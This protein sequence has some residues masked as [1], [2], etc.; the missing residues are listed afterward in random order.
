MLTIVITFCAL[1][2]S[3][4]DQAEDEALKMDENSFSQTENWQDILPN[5]FSTNGI[6]VEDAASL[7]DAIELAEAGSTI[8]LAPTDYNASIVLDRSD[9]SLIGMN[10]SN[11]AKATLSSLSIADNAANLLFSNIESPA[12]PD[13]FR[14]KLDDAQAFS[15]ARKRSKAPITVAR[16]SMSGNIAH[17]IFEIK[18][19]DGPYDIVRLH[20]V[21]RERRP[22]RIQPTQ[23]EVFMVHGASQDFE[24]IFYYAGEYENV[25]PMT[26][27]PEYL[28]SQGIDVWG[29]SLGWT[30]IPIDETDLTT[31]Q[32]WDLGK[33]VKHTLSAM[34]AARLI[35]ILTGQ[36]FGKLNLLGFSY[37]GAIAY[38]AA[39]KETQQHPIFRDI[40]GIIPVDFGLKYEPNEQNMPYIETEC[41]I[42]EN[43]KQQIADGN[44]VNDF[45][46]FIGLGNLAAIDPEGPSPVV[47]ELTN[48][49]FLLSTAV[50]PSANPSTEAW[51]FAAG[52]PAGLFFTD[53]DRWMAL[54]QHLA[55]YMP[56]FPRYELSKCFCNED[57]SSLDDYLEQIQVPILY[58]GAGGGFTDV[59]EYT[60]T[61]TASN[62]ISS[63]IASVNS[64]A[65]EDFG[66]ADLFMANN[67]PELVWDPLAL[68]LLNHH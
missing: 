23:G 30:A 42:S 15:K 32:E 1:I 68:W 36:G 39:G 28:A 14:V 7:S 49:Q 38:V 53:N 22:F 52:T 16:T 64:N 17:Y 44:Y 61:L 18:L 60:P 31:L 2:M 20:R 66:H 54:V 8:Y 65:F 9:I 33:D 55:P 50:V 24:D 19:G 62:D 27:S 21:V 26:S 59:G 56:S 37:G 43:I 58:I 57:D 3:C 45:S 12:I 47:P 5:I 35:R 34:A 63:F 6:F 4:N 29:I 40:K 13:Q 25:N 51:H 46:G 41:I 10:G 67:A 11:G 48:L